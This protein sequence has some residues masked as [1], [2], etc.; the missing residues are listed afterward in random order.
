MN[1]KKRFANDI[2]PGNVIH[3]GEIIHDEL[4]AREMSQQELAD[5]M[6]MSKSEIVQE[7]KERTPC[8]EQ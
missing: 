7:R 5:K 3:P 4:E 2:I 6:K 1:K 8:K